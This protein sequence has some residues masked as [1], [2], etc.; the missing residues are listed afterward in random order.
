[1]RGWVSSRCTICGIRVGN[2]ADLRA[3]ET[4]SIIEETSTSLDRTVHLGRDE[5]WFRRYDSSNEEGDYSTPN[6]P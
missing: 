5:G 6:S 2:G 3:T 1:M 4:Y